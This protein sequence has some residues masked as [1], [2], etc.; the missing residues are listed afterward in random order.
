[1]FKEES[2]PKKISHP[3]VITGTASLYKRISDKL[4]I[5]LTS[6]NYFRVPNYKYEGGYFLL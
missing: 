2:G 4:Y 1:M 6:A 5:I 3:S